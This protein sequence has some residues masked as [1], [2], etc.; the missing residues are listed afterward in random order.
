VLRLT[1]RQALGKK[2]LEEIL[3]DKTERGEDLSS[4]LRLSVHNSEKWDRV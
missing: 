2:T 4:G 3:A 1:V